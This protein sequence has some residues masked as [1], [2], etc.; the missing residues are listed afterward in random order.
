MT[1]KE[2]R[3]R[4]DHEKYRSEPGTKSPPETLTIA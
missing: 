3:T 2:F 4:L 1:P